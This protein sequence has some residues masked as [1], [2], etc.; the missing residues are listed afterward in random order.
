MKKLTKKW[1]RMFLLCICLAMAAPTASIAATNSVSIMYLGTKKT[2]K[3]LAVKTNNKKVVSVKKKGRKTI[4]SPKSEGEAILK[5]YKGNKLKKKVSVLVLRKGAVSYDTRNLVLRTGDKKAVKATA[6]KKC[7]ITYF[8][9]N[10][11]IATVNSK[12]V[13]TGIRSGSCT[14]TA[15][16][17]YKK[18][19]IKTFKKE[20]IISN[21]NAVSSESEKTDS[22]KTNNDSKNTSTEN[23]AGNNKTDKQTGNAENNQATNS[24]ANNSGTN[25]AGTNSQESGGLESGNSES[26]SSSEKNHL[27]S[28]DV[29]CNI[30]SVKEGYHFTLDDFVVYGNYSDGSRQRIYN[31][32]IT[33]TYA[34]ANGYYEI[35]I[36]VQDKSVML[37]VPVSISGA[38]DNYDPSIDNPVQKAEPTGIEVEFALTEIPENYDFPMSDFTVYTVYSDGSKKLAAGF[39]YQATYKDGYYYITV[40]SG[41]FKKELKVKASTSDIDPTVTKVKFALTYNTIKVGETF[42][43]GQIKVTAI[44]SDGTERDVTDFTHDFTPKTTPGKYTVNITWGNFKGTVTVDVVSNEAVMQSADIKFAREFLYLDEQ[45]DKSDI[46]VTGKYSDGTIRSVTDFIFTFTPAT[47]HGQKAELTITIEGKS[48]TLL[49]P[50]YDRNI[51]IGL[52]M[53]LTKPTIKVNEN[54]DP[55]TIIL[56]VEY[57]DGR[58]AVETDFS[59]DYTPK[60]VPGSYPVILTFRGETLEFIIEVVE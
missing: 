36:D 8:S 24:G 30:A 17:T 25:S 39:G 20:V 2:E 3:K 59:I 54:I 14:I 22:Y 48:T 44:Y 33:S 18:K 27:Q 9:S 42:A 4:I 55:K 50:C 41:N 31:F 49:I 35:I 11:K 19:K 1:Y 52:H 10:K 60:S 57:R 12:G 34:S 26:G 23:S 32:R 21:T 43:P 6:P 28:L 40:T 16:I 53:T 58:K 51:P 29:T 5:Y 13:I 47:G 38:D 37:K 7:K 46:I 56:D 45:P 15:K